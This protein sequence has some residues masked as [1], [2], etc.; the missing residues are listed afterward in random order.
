MVF[1]LMRYLAKR[2][3]DPISEGEAQALERYLWDDQS[4][5]ALEWVRAQMIE[6]QKEPTGRR[7][8]TCR[9]GE[10]VPPC[11][12]QVAHGDWLPRLAES[13]SLTNTDPEQ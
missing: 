11:P 4:Q 7:M 9:M 1:Q 5:R 2:G 12:M 13:R 6:R 10:Q 3:L 8:M